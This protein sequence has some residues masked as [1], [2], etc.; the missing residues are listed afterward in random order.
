MF[1]KGWKS[2]SGWYWLGLER[3]QD[4]WYGYII[5]AKQ[6]W[7]YF[8]ERDLKPALKNNLIKELTKEELKEIESNLKEKGVI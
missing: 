1:K 5:G 7:G 4:L 3:Y 2:I 6:E 8:D